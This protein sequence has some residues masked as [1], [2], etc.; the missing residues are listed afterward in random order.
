MEAVLKQNK[1]IIGGV[2]LAAAAFGVLL[3]FYYKKRNSVDNY[4][5]PGP[6]KVNLHHPGVG[7]GPAANNPNSRVPTLLY[8][9]GDWCP[10]CQNMMGDWAEVE[11][12]LQGKVRT[13]KIES[14]DPRMAN[15]QVQGFP[16][17]RACP[18][19]IEADA[20]MIE[21]KGPRQANEIINFAMQTLMT[22]PPSGGGAG[23]RMA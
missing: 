10:H 3:Y 8:L 1:Y 12:A 22:P 14:A 6:S 9:Y 7:Q 2:V 16:T 17:I 11:R 19:G 4:V 21:F 15:F 13:M 20:V 18:Q 23:Q 5:P